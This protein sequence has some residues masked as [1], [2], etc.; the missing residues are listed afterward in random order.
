M[1]NILSV[2][3]VIAGLLYAWSLQKEVF[4][5]VEV[6][7]VTITAVYPSSSSRDVEQRVIIPMERELKGLTGINS[8]NALSQEGI[9]RIV[10]EVEDDADLDKTVDDIKNAIDRVTDLPDIVESPNVHVRSSKDQQI[11][12]IILTG[13]NYLLLKDTAKDLRDDLERMGEMRRINLGGYRPDE[14]RLETNPEKLAFYEI[15]AKDIVD[16]VRSRNRSIPAGKIESSQGTLFLR[17]DAEFRTLDDV[18]NVIIRSNFSGENVKISDVATVSREPDD[19]SVRYRA[20]GAQAILLD[21]IIKDNA[22]IIASTE[23][24]KERVQQFFEQNPQLNDKI[25]HSYADEAASWVHRRLSILLDSGSMGFILVF[26]CLLLFL[27]LRTA[28]VTCL[29]APIAFMIAF[30]GMS[31]VG[32]TINMI[33]MFSLILV[34]GMLVDDSII[35]AEYY[36]QK[37]EAGLS[38]KDAARAAAVETIRPVSVTIITSMVAFGSFYFVTGTM[39][40]FMWSIPTVVIICLAASLLE[41]YFILPSHLCD[42]VRIK[43]EEKN[44]VWYTAAIN[45]YRKVLEKLLRYYALVLIGFVLLFFSAIWTAN[46]MKVELFPGDDVRTVFFQFRGKLGNTLERTDKILSRVEKLTLKTLPQEELEQIA[47]RVGM[48]TERDRTKT[49]P[50]Y[51]SLILYLTPPLDRKRSTDEIVEDLS[52]KLKPIL[53]EYILTIRKLQGGPPSGKPVDIELSGNNLEEIYRAAEKVETKLKDIPGIVTTEIDF[54]RGKKQLSFNVKDA[55]ARRLGLSTQDVALEL[56]RIFSNES[57]DIQ[58][59]QDEDIDIKLFLEGPSPEAN[60]STNELAALDK[61]YIA[62]KQNRRIPLSR[63]V[64]IEEKPIPF[65]IRRKDAKRTISVTAQ[66]NSDIIT[67]VEV[68][69]KISPEVNKI[70][71]EHPTVKAYFGGENEETKSSMNSMLKAFFLSFGLIFVV[72]IGLF[73]TVRHTITVMSAIP[74]GAIGVIY[75]FK[76]ADQSL[77]FMSMMGIVGLVG[78]VINNSIVLVN[79]INKLRVTEKDLFKVVLDGSVR[80]FRAV[81]LTTVTT[82]AGLLFLA[83]P[84]LA[85][86]FSF[87]VNTDSDPFLQPMAMS[88][89]WGLIFA[90]AITLF[91]IPS[92][93]LALEKAHQFISNRF[94]HQPQAHS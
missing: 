50:H 47:A 53:D 61:L 45:L 49:A 35:V 88:F 37:L 48:L 6:G 16:A 38:P 56:R 36:F 63:L 22:D 71:Q 39:G 24:I 77:S 94:S 21:V 82:A 91:F 29:G 93:Y 78:V 43:P 55:E 4:P 67:P 92:L 87:G 18:R 57:F 85:K 17:V 2:F 27:N 66:N 40:K 74:L 83:H 42:F 26:I 68:V 89:A 72:L 64:E 75:T 32:V 65:I 33:S 80:R 44:P 41:C 1:V 31:M 12:S 86:I 46:T 14:I 7:V 25:Q 54:E 28:I 58:R 11:I 81:I 52:Q 9:G 23:R 79:F 60:K 10:I 15:T 84:I 5:R 20:N 13:K 3:I 19:T 62:N 90:S 34:L 69:N 73:G 8:M 51:G 59:E 30:V 70:L 76:I